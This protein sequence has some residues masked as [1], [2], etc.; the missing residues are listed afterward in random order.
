M[1]SKVERP[2][3]KPILKRVGRQWSSVGRFLMAYGPAHKSPVSSKS[4]RSAPESPMWRK[5]RLGAENARP[6]AFQRSEGH[7]RS[8]TSVGCETIGQIFSNSIFGGGLW[9]SRVRKRSSH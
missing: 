4:T 7:R 6:V 3:I 1:R 5:I 9:I 8:G 2:A